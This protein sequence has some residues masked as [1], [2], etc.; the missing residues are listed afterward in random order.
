[1]QDIDCCAAEGWPELGRERLDK[2]ERPVL[3]R[4]KC[5]THTFPCVTWTEWDWKQ[6]YIDILERA[7]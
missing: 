5:K 1:M 6:N 4:Q 3:V 7:Y 2:T